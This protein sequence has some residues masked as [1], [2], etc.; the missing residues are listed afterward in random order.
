MHSYGPISEL[1]QFSALI[2]VQKSVIAHSL[3]R[4]VHSA[5]RHTINLL[6]CAMGINCTPLRA[7]VYTYYYYYYYSY[8]YYVSPV[9]FV[10]W[11]KYDFPCNCTLMD[12][13][14][15]Y[16]TFLHRYGCKKSVIA[17]LL[18]RKFR[19]AQRHTINYNSTPWC[20]RCWELIALPCVLL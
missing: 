11:R 5:R 20:M 15:S 1:L 18:V 19:S 13:S 6:V 14:A 10:Q 17:R 2:R 9:D 16:Y 4:N 7:V 12:Q 8:A 3:V